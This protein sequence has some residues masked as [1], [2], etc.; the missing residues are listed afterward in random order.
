MNF[1]DGER[2][3]LRGMRAVTTDGEGHEIY[4]GLDRGE[5]EE[6]LTLSRRN[7]AGEDMSSDPRFADLHRRHED[8]RQRIVAGERPLDPGPE[9]R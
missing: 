6:F 4:V 2:E 3:M 1:T 8:A 7:E 5:S 9:R